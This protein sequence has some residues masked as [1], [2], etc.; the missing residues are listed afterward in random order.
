M[1]GPTLLHAAPGGGL[2]APSILRLA[3][4]PR[5]GPTGVP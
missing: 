1:I 2:Q 4:A 5:T 3:T